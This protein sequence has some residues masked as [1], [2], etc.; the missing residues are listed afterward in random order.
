MAMRNISYTHTPLWKK[1]IDLEMA[2]TMENNILITNIQRFSLHDG[3]G[4]RTTVFLKGC[5][6]C[7]PWCSNPE[8]IIASL[9]PYIREGV[10][11]IYGKYYSP[12]ELTRE[13]LKDKAFYE[14]KTNNWSKTKAE[15][16]ELLPGGVTFSG[17]EC[18]LQMGKL[19]PVC[20]EL[21]RQGIHI[22]AETCLFVPV[23]SLHLALQYI[24]FF[25]VDV[26]I[27]DGERC[28]KVEH[29]N[30]DLY[31]ENLDILLNWKDRQGKGKPVVIR[32][33]VIGSY[34]DY[35]ENRRAV[36]MLLKK[37]KDKILKIQLIKEHN[38]GESKYRSLGW[39]MD[40]HGV[41]DILLEEYKR[42]LADLELPIEV[43]KV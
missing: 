8:N 11:G 24:D 22:A 31:L 16:I 1:S 41:N 10:S 25:Y 27:L 14:G 33:P 7:C 38:L 23:S 26:K 42:E 15:E 37:Y 32:I 4:I 20:E 21:H 2:E 40:Y 30:L 18:L 5:S 19:V 12:E 3:P 43:C 6:L 28:K 35:E 17:G 39:N 29:G 13:C 36:M 34:T 9:Q